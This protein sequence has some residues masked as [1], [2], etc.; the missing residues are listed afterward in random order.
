MRKQNE[1][2]NYT[3]CSSEWVSPRERGTKK[4][5]RFKNNV[6]ER[7]KT[8]WCLCVYLCARGE[9]E[10]ENYSAFFVSY[11]TKCQHK[12]GLA[13]LSVKECLARL[14]FPPLDFLFQKVL[15][16]PYFCCCKNNLWVQQMRR[17][18]RAMTKLQNLKGP[19][20]RSSRECEYGALLP[21]EPE[22]CYATA[23]DSTGVWGVGRGPWGG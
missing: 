12:K 23:Q 17:L 22:G 19:Q 13:Q 8:G 6:G 4:R 21:C 14:L 16:N 9:S 1:K 11:A 2:V 20:N 18:R 3:N 10:L 15:C 5:K 7:R